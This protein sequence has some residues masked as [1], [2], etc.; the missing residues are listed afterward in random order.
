M[1]H[2]YAQSIHLMSSIQNRIH[3]CY[4]TLHPNILARIDSLWNFTQA[5][6][7][8]EACEGEVGRRVSEAIYVWTGY[9]T[10]AI[11]RTVRLVEEIAY[12]TVFGAT[13]NVDTVSIVVVVTLWSS[14]SS[15]RQGIISRPRYINLP[16]VDGAIHIGVVVDLQLCSCWANSQQ[17]SQIYKVEELH[18]GSFEKLRQTLESSH[19]DGDF[20]DLHRSS[21]KTPL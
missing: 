5:G 15:L 9:N 14:L 16:G 11:P 13:A 3:I 6:S 19:M 1:I 21:V 12:A 18:T 10:G 7:T 8:I 2:V 20:P 4:L 17:N